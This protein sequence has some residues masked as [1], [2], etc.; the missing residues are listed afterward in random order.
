MKNFYKRLLIFF[1][2]IIYSKIKIANK[3]FSQKFIFKKLKFGNLLVEI[4]KIK[5][6]RVFTNTLDVAIIK[7]KYL[8]NGPSLQ[9]RENKNA[10]V[11]ENIVFKNGTPKLYKKI[12]S[13]VFSLLTGLD[14][15]VNYYHWFFDC[16][17]KIYFYQKYYKFKKDDYFLVPNYK[18]EF[19]KSS[20][21]IL[22]LHNILNA[23]DIKHF[24]I[25]ELITTNFS[26]FGVNP[27]LSYIKYIRNIF[28]KK[29]NFKNKKNKYIYL[30]R[31]GLTSKY[32]DIYNK[33]EIF[34]LLRKKK[35][36]IVDPVKLN[37]L[38]QIKLFNSSKKIISVHGGAFTNLIFCKKKTKVIELKNRNS[39]NNTIGN[40]AKKLELNF[41]VIYCKKI[42]AVKN[43]RGWDGLFY[44]NKNILIKKIK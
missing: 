27:P 7:N 30:D 44:L 23:Y 5:N 16:L 29:I 22:G 26:N 13:R 11:K 19:Q 15:N 10:N 12:N 37:L 33:K 39:K 42:I 14:S 32:R 43:N 34:S 21:K 41:N 17:P 28:L 40:I 9:I 2:K 24:S 35:F 6:C 25:K 4:Y 8:L 1:Y 20:L 31:I 36:K 18:Y 3:N 38:S